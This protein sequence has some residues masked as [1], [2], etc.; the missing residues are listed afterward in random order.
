[1]TKIE[2]NWVLYD[3]ANSAFI[4]ILTALLPIYYGSIARQ[5]GLSE[6]QITAV[7]GTMLSLSAL[8]V[9]LVSPVLG[10][11]AD[12]KGMR[13]KMFLVFLLI[14]VVGCFIFGISK[15][16]VYIAIIMAVT[17]LGFQGSLV[18]YDAMLV[19]VTTDERMDRVS[20]GGYAWGYIGSC[21]PF[22]VCLALYVFSTMKIGGKILLPFSDSTAIII[23]MAITGVWW[24]ALSTPLLKNYEQTHGVEPTN[25]QV[26]DS[27]KKIGNTLKHIGEYKECFMFILAFFFYINGVTTIIGMSISYAQSVLGPDAISSILMVVALLMTQF[28]AFPFAILFGKLADKYNPRKLIFI[29]ICGY[30]AIC[31]YGYFLKSIVDFFI[32]AFFVGLFQG[33]IQALS[34]SYFAKLVPKDKSNELFGVFDISGKGAAIIGPLFMSL[35]IAITKNPRW[36]IVALIIFFIVGG[37]ILLAIPKNNAD[38]PNIKYKEL[39][40]D[41][42]KAQE[43]EVVE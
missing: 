9:A 2:K 13:K 15:S 23:G 6:A 28:V 7:F 17:K 41:K 4:M 22:I 19:D 39:L 31:I 36:G 12:N 24:F 26:K 14:G 18:F 1:M 43:S 29:A 33:G 38:L 30:T 32:L 40:K 20:A 8:V 11:I 21:A 37:A 10:A 5:A 25:H 42:E 27:F 34:R 35:A 3:V 16:I